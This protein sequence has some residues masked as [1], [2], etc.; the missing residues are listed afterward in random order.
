MQ[1][2]GSPFQLN[3]GVDYVQVRAHKV[4]DYL[5]RAILDAQNLNMLEVGKGRDGFCKDAQ[6]FLGAYYLALILDFPKIALNVYIRDG[7]L[8]LGKQRA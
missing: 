6:I 8:H 7:L 2:C 1:T 5:I 3:A 4:D